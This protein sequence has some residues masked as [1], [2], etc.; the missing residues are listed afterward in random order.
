MM[1]IKTVFFSSLLSYVVSQF[2]FLLLFFCRPPIYRE[3]NRANFEERRTKDCPSWKVDKCF[4]TLRTRVQPTM[5]IRTVLMCRGSCRS[6]TATLIYTWA[7]QSFIRLFLVLRRVG[8]LVITLAVESDSHTHVVAIA[9]L[10]RSDGP[11]SWAISFSIFFSPFSGCE[12]MR[13]RWPLPKRK[14]DTCVS[15][16]MWHNRWVVPAIRQRCNYFSNDMEKKWRILET[17]I[18]QM[19]W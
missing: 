2:Y 5:P 9:T 19:R 6:S 10:R 15:S 16:R 18:V 3:K 1:T 8:L 17:N 4:V 13:H 14:P 12:T 11:H 7:A